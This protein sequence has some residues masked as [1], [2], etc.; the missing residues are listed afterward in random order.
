[1][2]KK[3]RLGVNVDH[4]ATIR[5]ARG[6]YYPSVAQAAQRALEAGAD[7]ITIHLREDRRHIQDSDLPEVRIVTQRLGK[8]FNLEMGA[9]PEMTQIAIE[10]QPDWICLVPEKREEVTTEGGLDLTNENVYQRVSDCITK[11]R[12]QLPLIKVSLFLESSHDI[13]EKAVLLQ[14]DAVEVHTGEYAKLFLENKDFSPLIDSF[15]SAKQFLE[16]HK[17]KVHAGH[18]LTL[19]SVKPLVERN[20]FEEYNIG[21]WIIA[22]AIFNGLTNVVES[23]NTLF[24][25]MKGV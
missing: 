24:E 1:M 7:Q 8:L 4:V 20:L 5:E 3:I 22:Q 18:G 14:A 11:V 10:Q 13:L 17:I 25:Q 6:E 15:T 12:E 9:T 21:H 19:E 2:S 16:D 23:F